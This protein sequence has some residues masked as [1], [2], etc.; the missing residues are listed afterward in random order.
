MADYAPHSVLYYPSIEFQS[1]EWLKKA[2]LFWD[3]VYRIVPEGYTP[4][5]SY[6]VK[7]FIDNG[8][9]KNIP[10]S[11]GEK[12]K[13]AESFLKFRENL[14]YIPSGLNDVIVDRLSKQKVDYRL[15]RLL[16][17]IADKFDFK[18]DKDW[19]YFPPNIARGYLFTLA[20]TI[21]ES[22]QLVRATDSLD[23]WSVSPYFTEKGNFPFEDV[24]YE[25]GNEG[26][27]CSLMIEDVLP[28]NVVGISAQ[29]IIKLNE[30]RKDE[31]I[32]FRNRIN[33]LVYRLPKIKSKEQ[34]NDEMNFLL[35]DFERD[36]Q[37]FK[38]IFGPVGSMMRNSA[39]A[40]G[41]PT[42][43]TAVGNEILNGGI[44]LLQALS[45][46]AIS[47]ITNFN[48]IKQNRNPSY[49]S[50]LIDIDKQTKNIAGAAHQYMHEFIND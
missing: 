48:L 21:A 15:I 4:D 49:A 1:E 28:D 14:Q 50:Y 26:V 17:Y 47:T 22:R 18:T 46:A 7:A 31:R 42:L 34:W 44:T 37:N 9:V 6:E 36:K 23:V 19:Y 12:I 32:L 43:L 35:E 33:E 16:D 20:Q 3:H 5:D 30:E 39:M 38:K 29:T 2:L 41:V 13:A 25:K 45:I 10:V 8:L 40:V 24:P 11:E 27:Y